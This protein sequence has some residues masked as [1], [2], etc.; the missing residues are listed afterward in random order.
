MFQAQELDKILEKKKKIDF[1][2]SISLDDE[3][4]IKRLSRGEFACLAAQAIIR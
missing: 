1:V 4:I 3:E 2:L